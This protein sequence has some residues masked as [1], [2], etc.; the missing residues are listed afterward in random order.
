MFAGLGSALKA[1][2]FVG[3]CAT[4]TVKTTAADI[5][6]QT[7]IERRGVDDLDRRRLTAFSL[8][9]FLWMGA[10]QYVLY[11]RVFEAVLPAK[12]VL[13]SAGKMVLDQ[14]VHVP[15]LFLPIF[16]SVDAW[17]RG[18]GLEHVRGKYKNEALTTL[19]AN[20]TIWVPASFVSFFLVPIHW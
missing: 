5:T 6:V 20:W 14:F 10:G 11:C 16:Y 2:P 13:H 1:R 3:A 4:V 9:G 8:F 19:K 17:V 15:L 12:T 7:V 18:E